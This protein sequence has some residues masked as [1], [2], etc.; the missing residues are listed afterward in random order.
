MECLHA[1]TIRGGYKSTIHG[2][3]QTQTKLNGLDWVNYENE[4]NVS[5]I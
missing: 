5:F 2:F 4:L 3:I 1:P